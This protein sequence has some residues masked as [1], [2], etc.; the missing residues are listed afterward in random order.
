MDYDRMAALVVSLTFMVR[1]GNGAKKLFLFPTSDSL[2]GTKTRS[3]NSTH[4]KQTRLWVV[5]HRVRR[6]GF[7]FPSVPTNGKSLAK[8]TFLVQYPCI[9]VDRSQQTHC[10]LYSPGIVHSKMSQEADYRIRDLQIEVNLLPSNSNSPRN[11]SDAPKITQSTTI[12]TN[13]SPSFSFSSATESFEL[14]TPTD[15][16]TKPESY[17]TM[18]LTPT[19]KIPIDEAHEKIKE[20]GILKLNWVKKHHVRCIYFLYG[21]GY[22]RDDNNDTRVEKIKKMIVPAKAFERLKSIAVSELQDKVMLGAGAFEKYLRFAS[23]VRIVFKKKNAGGGFPR[24]AVLRTQK[25]RN[26][27]L[28]S[29]CVWATLQS[30]F[31]LPGNDKACQ[32]PDISQVARRHI[33][34]EDVGAASFD[35]RLEDRVVH[36]RGYS[37]RKLAQKLVGREGSQEA[38]WRIFMLDSGEKTKDKV[39]YAWIEWENNILSTYIEAL[40]GKQ[41]KIGLVTNFR[42]AEPF[43]TAS[44][45][46]TSGIGYWKFDGDNIDTQGEF[47]NLPEDE[48]CGT[49]KTRLLKLWNRQMEDIKAEK[50]FRKASL[51]SLF[52]DSMFKN[53]VEEEGNDE[54]RLDQNSPGRNDQAQDP[55]HSMVLLGTVREMSRRPSGYGKEEER[56]F[57]VLLNS[58]GNM[59]CVLVSIEYLRACGAYVNFIFKRLDQ[60]PELERNFRL[61]GECSFHE[62]GGDDSYFTSWEKE[63]DDY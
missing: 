61:A 16:P 8:Q 40:V 34:D 7:I 11:D 43:R 59:P 35:R 62:D 13:E 17:E 6:V 48:D 9:Q 5:S 23:T 25:S 47:V 2:A 42:V 12:S 44:E 36:D 51:D 46:E 10:I 30:Q 28:T 18:S 4:K 63:E 50:D 26:C 58:W 45:K 55:K 38:A 15:P 29:A 27:Y 14:K 24:E 31:D 57:F 32:L 21:I 3:E 1:K 33:L 54:E 37:A 60:V 53:S 39:D 52:P 22:A 41:H 56:V 49:E 19:M 20:D